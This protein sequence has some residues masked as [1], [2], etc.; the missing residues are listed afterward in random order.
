MTAEGRYTNGGF[1]PNVYDRYG[2][3]IVLYVFTAPSPGEPDGIQLGASDVSQSPVVGSRSPW[4]V[5]LPISLSF[6]APA[7]CVVAA[8]P[9]HDPQFA[10]APTPST[11]PAPTASASPGEQ[12]PI[13]VESERQMKAA[14]NDGP[15]SSILLPTSCWLTG[16]TIT[17]EGT[18]AN[19]GFVPNLYN[20]YGDIIV[21]YVLA[22]PS[23]GYPHGM[24]L[25]VSDVSQS[26]VVGSP[27]P[28][29]V[30][31]SISPSVGVP[32]RCVVAAQP[33]HDLQLAP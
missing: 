28:W 16:T 10:P 6:G 17:A 30:S 13:S 8:Q 19:G 31:L 1:V 21:L 9:T 11:T 12:L 25:G 33:T 24:Q 2:D 3:V 5:S 14:G 15:S 22:P 26:P 27:A 4:H 29:H 23:A 7:R 18:Y 20:R 32:A